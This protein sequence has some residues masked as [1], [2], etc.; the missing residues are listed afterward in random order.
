MRKLLAAVLLLLASV[1]VTAC[2]D[3]TGPE[4]AEGTY[5]LA[6]V[7]GSSL[8]AVVFQVGSD[9]LEVVAG[10]LTL[11][12]NSS[13][14]GSLTIRETFQGTTNTE[15]ESGTGTYTRSGNTITFNSGDDETATGTLSGNTLTISDEGLTLVYRK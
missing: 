15:T 4:S 9:K 10:T 3:S 12:S 5:T 14:T 11:S 7:N 1:A 2:S 8:P 6:T 13:F